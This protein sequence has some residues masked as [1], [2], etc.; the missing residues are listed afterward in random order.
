M[1]IVSLWL[2]TAR[3]VRTETDGDITTV[4]VPDGSRTVKDGGDVTQL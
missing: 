4:G 2:P 3:A 1:V